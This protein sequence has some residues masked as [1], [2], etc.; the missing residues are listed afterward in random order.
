MKITWAPNP[1]RT[2][3]E[4][5]EH[6]KR[7]FRER[8]RSLYLE[9]CITSAHFTLSAEWQRNGKT[10]EESMAEAVRTLDMGFTTCGEERNGETLEKRLDEQ[11]ASYLEDLAGEHSGDCTCVPCSCTKCYAENILGIDTIKGLG[12][13]EASKIGVFFKGDGVSIDDVVDR[14]KDYRPVYTPNPNWPEADWQQHVPRWTEE[15]RRAHEWLT[16]YRDKH[17]HE[18]GVPSRCAGEE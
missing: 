8:L 17:A 2:T 18:W 1:L 5:D 4:L 3:I 10:P 16:M 11:L 13:H 9:N 6:E 14:L 15:G 7:W 12:K